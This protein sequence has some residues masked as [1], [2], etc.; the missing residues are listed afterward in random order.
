MVATP[1]RCNQ[2]Y[3]RML[4][5]HHERADIRADAYLD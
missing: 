2:L 3:G 5:I 4:P 1:E